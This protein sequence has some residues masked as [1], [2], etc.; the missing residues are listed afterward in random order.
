MTAK[1]LKKPKCEVKTHLACNG[2]CVRK[3]TG[4]EKGDPKFNCCI[5]CAWYLKRQGVRL[6]EVG[7]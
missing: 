6:K 1:K 4:P 5:G 7:S 3:Y 2:I